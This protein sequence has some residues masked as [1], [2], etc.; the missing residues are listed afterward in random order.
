MDIPKCMPQ[1]SI[2][3]SP[4]DPAWMS[5]LVHSEVYAEDKVLCIN[6]KERLSLFNTHISEVITE[7]RRKPAVI[8]SVIDGRAWRR[9][10][11][12]INLDNFLVGLSD[13]FANLC[14]DDSHVRP[15]D[16]DIPD[17]VKPL[18]ISERCV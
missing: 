3:M 11:S 4:R 9:R 8:G 6:N 17:C 7:N 10:S 16:M 14:Y 5:P 12:S 2:R 13:Y 1:K 15:I 18:E